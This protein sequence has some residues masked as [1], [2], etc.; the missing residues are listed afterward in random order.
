MYRYTPPSGPDQLRLDALKGGAPPPIAPIERTQQRSAP[1]Q[2]GIDRV[3]PVRPGQVATGPA[4]R[5]KLM[6]DGLHCSLCALWLETQ[7]MGG[8][9]AGQ[10][11]GKRA[12]RQVSSVFFP[13]VEGGTAP[14]GGEVLGDE[15]GGALQ[16]GLES[17]TTTLGPGVPLQRPEPQAGAVQLERAPAII[18]RGMTAR[19]ETTGQVVVLIGDRADGRRLDGATHGCLE[20]QDARGDPGVETTCRGRL[21]A[22][23]ERG[24][25]ESAIAKPRVAVGGIGRTG[26][27]GAALGLGRKD[28]RDVDPLGRS[29]PSISP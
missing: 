21:P 28:G 22:R 1:E 15:S 20:G 6:A 19:R 14:Q 2:A 16:V 10:A 7:P 3:V 11:R 13:G 12:R 9:Q 23:I 25:A 5:V 17:V 4:A 29:S 8:K 27:D 18:G 26:E 24:S